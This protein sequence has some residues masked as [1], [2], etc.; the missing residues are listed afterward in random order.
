MIAEAYINKYSWIFRRLRSWWKQLGTEPAY[1]S[2]KENHI[3]DLHKN[4]KWFVKLEGA[5]SVLEM[6]ILEVTA[7][8]VLTQ[9]VCDVYIPPA[10]YEITSITWIEKKE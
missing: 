3:P 5:S 9:V 10:R 8:T 2:K 4:E 7:H 6:K 1:Q